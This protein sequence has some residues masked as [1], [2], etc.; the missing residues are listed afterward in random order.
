M[1]RSCGGPVTQALRSSHLSCALRSCAAWSVPPTEAG[2]THRV[3]YPETCE[4]CS[5]DDLRYEYDRHEPVLMEIGTGQTVEMPAGGKQGVLQVTCAACGGV[6]VHSVSWFDPPADDARWTVRTVGAAKV[7]DHA[8]DRVSGSSS[9]QQ[10]SPR[11][12]DRDAP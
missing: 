1:N 5:S 9:D 3:T 10:D 12:N 6:T 7:G 2:Y 8:N 11:Y 4:R